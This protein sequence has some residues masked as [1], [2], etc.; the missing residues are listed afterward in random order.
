M[1]DEL[2]FECKD[3][4]DQDLHHV[5]GKDHTPYSSE[6]DMQVKNRN[7]SVQQRA[8][9]PDMYG[10]AG[11]SDKCQLRRVLGPQKQTCKD[12]AVD[13]ESIVFFDQLFT[14]KLGSGCGYWN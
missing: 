11:W 10:T 2:Q 1:T 13:S 5:S 12:Y 3:A 9:V 8:P 14:E 7:W 4:K 6:D